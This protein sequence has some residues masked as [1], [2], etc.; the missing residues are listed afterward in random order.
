LARPAICQLDLSKAIAAGAV[1]CP[2][3][4]RQRVPPKPDNPT[5]KILSAYIEPAEANDVPANQQKAIAT[6]A[7][8]AAAKPML[9]IRAFVR[10]NA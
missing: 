1:I 8:R 7:R 10:P 5:Q 4:T 9:Q 6:E 3:Q 2:R